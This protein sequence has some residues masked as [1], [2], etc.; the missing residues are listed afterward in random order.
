MIHEHEW[1]LAGAKATVVIAHGLAEHVHRYDHVAESLNDAGYAVKAADM[2]GHGGSVGFP[3]D[4]GSDA[5]QLID[6]LSERVTDADFVYAHSAGTLVALSVA[7][8]RRALRGLVLSGVAILPTEE[9]VMGMVSGTIA[10]E[11]VSRDPAVVQAY[12]DDPLV[13]PDLIMASAMG[14][15]LDATGRA[16]DAL[17]TVTCPVLLM[18][19][20][21]DRI[22][23]VE[24]ARQAY[25]E[26]GSGDKTLKIYDGLY[27]EV[28]NEPEQGQVLADVARWLDA[29]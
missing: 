17:P 18:H 10:P 5:Q 28:H 29:H 25:D 4:M 27:H 15:L 11:T 12:I 16:V 19:G 3:D 26:I 13:R 6:D 23:S 21:A 22:C 2:R 8:H 20:G 7:A 1:P 24:G 14:L 9:M